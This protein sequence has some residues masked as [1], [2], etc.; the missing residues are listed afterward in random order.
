MFIF[1]MFLFL[2]LQQMILARQYRILNIL[3]MNSFVELYIDWL[4]AHEANA[5]RTDGIDNVE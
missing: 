4:T 5:Y 3:F 1:E 2:A